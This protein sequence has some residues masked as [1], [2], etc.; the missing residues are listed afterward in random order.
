[1]IAALDATSALRI[2]YPLTDTTVSGVVPIKV[3]LEAD[4]AKQKPY[5]SL[6]VDRELKVLRNFAPYEY[7]WDTTQTVNGWHTV[8]A[9]GQTAEMAKPRKARSVRI[10]VNNGTGETR[11]LDK[12]EDLRPSTKP[13][14]S[15]TISVEK[16]NK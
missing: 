16:A 3:Q 7:N 9:W 12:I 8:E 13:K 15:V 4:L 1:H 2:N 5:V 10:N 11:K 14:A 6:F